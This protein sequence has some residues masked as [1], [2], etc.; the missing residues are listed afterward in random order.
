MLEPSGLRLS[1]FAWFPEHQQWTLPLVARIDRSL[2]R[3][4]RL[5]VRN[6][7]LSNFARRTSLYVAEFFPLRARHRDAT[8]SCGKVF[9]RDAAVAL[10]KLAV[11]CSIVTCQIIF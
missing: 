9:H 11:S 4:L 10:L 8:V 5:R 6:F 7:D 3:L 1:R 2:Q